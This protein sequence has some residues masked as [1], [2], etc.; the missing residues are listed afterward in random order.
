MLFK[1][2]V[3]LL[4]II[5]AAAAEDDC[6][7]IGGPPICPNDDL[8]CRRLICGNTPSSASCT[9]CDPEGSTI[10][11]TGTCSTG[12]CEVGPPWNLYC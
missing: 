10:R 12:C 4:T 9:W 6:G 1:T 3:V 5:A 11:W 7:A 8:T 2:I